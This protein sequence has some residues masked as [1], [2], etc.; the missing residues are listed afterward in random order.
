METL[1]EVKEKVLKYIQVMARP[2]VLLEDVHPIRW[3]GL[4]AD[5]KVRTKQTKNVFSYF[6]QFQIP[7]YHP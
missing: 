7:L 1:A 4:H 2:L 3:T 6:S 5:I